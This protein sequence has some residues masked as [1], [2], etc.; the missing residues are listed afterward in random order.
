[1]DI[2]LVITFIVIAFGIVRL[3]MGPG[4]CKCKYCDYKIRPYEIHKCKVS[5]SRHTCK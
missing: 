1:M 5:G 3:I 2:F 4:Y